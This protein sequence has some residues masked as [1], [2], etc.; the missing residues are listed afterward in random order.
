MHRMELLGVEAQMEAR[1]G[2]FRD[3]VSFSARLVH[4]LRQMYHSLRNRFGHTGLY[5]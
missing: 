1:F 5:S 2:P 3:S 4:S